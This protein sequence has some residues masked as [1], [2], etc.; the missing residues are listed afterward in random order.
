[1]SMPS[2]A[3]RPAAFGFPWLPFGFLP[4]RP[5]GDAVTALILADLRAAEAEHRARRADPR[6]ERRVLALKAHQR[7]SAEMRYADFLADRRHARAVRF[8]IDELHGSGPVAGE[9]E[10]I[11]GLLAALP[12][13]VPR[14]ALETLGA[15][16]GLHALSEALDTDMG[17]HLPDGPITPQDYAAAWRAT[18]RAGDR[19]R[20]VALTL[21]IGERLDGHT[22]D[23]LLGGTLRLMRGPALLAGLGSLQTFLETGFD[24]FAS[25]RGAAR[26]LDAIDQ[27][28]TAF[29]AQL[30]GGNGPQA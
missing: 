16:V 23:P 8:F 14:E 18:G 5:A 1:M 4:T 9:D 21:A 28:E 12:G 6:L 3:V 29:Q 26:F 13:M 22:R 24:A 30:F 25:M 15:L 11:A 20:Q 19:Q 27:R 7:D 10:Q 2:S 17:H